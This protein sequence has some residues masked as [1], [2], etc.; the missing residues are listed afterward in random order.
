MVRF[1]ASN[2]LL[3]AVVGLRIHTLANKFNSWR[4]NGSTPPTEE[5]VLAFLGQLFCATS[6]VSVVQSAAA[7]LKW[8][9]KFSPGSNPVDSVWIRAFLDGLRRQAPPVQHHPKVTEAEMRLIAGWEPPTIKDRRMVTYLCLLYAACLR[10][11]EGLQLLW[12]QIN[13]SDSDMQ[14]RVEK[15]KTRKEGPP[16]I[17]P[18]RKSSSSLCAVHIL[19]NWLQ[20]APK[21]EFVFPSLRNPKIAFSYGA[22]RK[23]LAR[24]VGALGLQENLTLHGFRGGSATAAIANGAPIDE[25]MRFGGWKRQATLDAYVEVSAATVPTASASFDYL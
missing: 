7:A 4:R 2:I 14:I 1:L 12:N 10:P 16:R 5:E 23:E 21:S 9:M 8:N 15:D 17:T 20:V 19:Q 6:S 13:F 18:I 24:L 11:S 3:S 22:A 25:V